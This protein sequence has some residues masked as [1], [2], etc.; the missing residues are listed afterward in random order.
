MAISAEAYVR[1]GAQH[2]YT[3]RTRTKVTA[4][5]GS[6]GA[7][8]RKPPI[9][10]RKNAIL[11]CA[12]NDGGGPHNDGHEEKQRNRRAQCIQSEVKRYERGWFA[13]T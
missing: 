12:Y 9:C 11:G 4:A 7:L 13:R 3:R 10:G 6:K 2:R 8:G 5:N 1:G